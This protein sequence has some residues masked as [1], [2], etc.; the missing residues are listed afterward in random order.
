MALACGDQVAVRDLT[1]KRPLTALPI[2]TTEALAFSPTANLV[3]VG[4]WNATGQ[5]G[6]GLWDVS[7]S[8]VA[9]T[10]TREAEGR[11]V[12]FSPDDRLLAV[13]CV[14]GAVR[15]L[16]VLAILAILA[17]RRQAQ[18]DPGSQRVGHRPCGLHVFQHRLSFLHAG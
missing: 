9:K 8:K 7:T 15:L 12:A 18:T 4:T 13:G 3:A 17:A 6:F 5:P 1:S 11:S 14:N 2:A 16:V 10:L